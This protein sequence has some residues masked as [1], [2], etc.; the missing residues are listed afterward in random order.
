M[1]ISYDSL[2]L[3]ISANVSGASRGI[4]SL[5]RNLEAL[6][7]TVKH[8]DFGL[9]ESLQKHLQNIANILLAFVYLISLLVFYN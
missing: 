3:N 2:E 8:L 1:A 6:Q 4:R 5:Q 7:N 9:I